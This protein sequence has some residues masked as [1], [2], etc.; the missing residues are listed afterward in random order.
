[1][2]STVSRWP[3][4]SNPTDHHDES[5]GPAIN[6]NSASQPDA[7]CVAPVA[8]AATTSTPAPS[9]LRVQRCLATGISRSA[10]SCSWADGHLP[11]SSTGHPMPANRIGGSRLQIK[12]LISIAAACPRCLMPSV[13]CSVS[14]TYASVRISGPR[15][16]SHAE[17]GL[18]NQ[19]WKSVGGAPGQ[20]QRSSAVILTGSA[21]IVACPPAG[22]RPCRPFSIH[23]RLGP[24]AGPQCSPP[25]PPRRN[26]GCAA[27]PSAAGAAPS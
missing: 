7:R 4:A 13:P 16:T 22:A 10:S 21:K 9:N 19:S 8:D 12:P 23:V 3:K 17:P 25:R 20:N 26:R 18:M 1:M 6:V 14:R 27:G 5:W 2:D 11:Q 15:A 24:R